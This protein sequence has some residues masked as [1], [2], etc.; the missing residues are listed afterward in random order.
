[1]C[2]ILIHGVTGHKALESVLD[3]CTI[4]PMVDGS[5]S[6]LRMFAKPA[7]WSE[8]NRTLTLKCIKFIIRE[9]RPRLGRPRGRCGHS[10]LGFRRRSRGLVGRRVPSL[11]NILRG[12][13]PARSR[14]SLS[15]WCTVAA[16]VH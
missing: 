3:H 4:T 5:Y 10:V 1:M 12:A 6:T 11:C 14:R 13:F 16:L 15:E 7:E 8:F 9:S 2:D